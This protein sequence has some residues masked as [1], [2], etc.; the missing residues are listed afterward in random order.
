VQ[1]NLLE[2]GLDVLQKM[3]AACGRVDGD[4]QI[5]EKVGQKEKES[6]GGKEHRPPGS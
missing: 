2:E 3:V 1:E 6:E 4:L 5:R